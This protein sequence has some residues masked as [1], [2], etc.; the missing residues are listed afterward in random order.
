M[1]FETDFWDT[2]HYKNNE[3]TAKDVERAESQLNVKF[4]ELL[5]KLLKIQ[6]G[7]YLKGFVFPINFRTSW[8]DD[9]VP[10]DELFGINFDEIGTGESSLTSSNYLTEEWGLP[11]SQVVLTGDGHW[12]ITLDYR[13]N[14]QTP[15]ISWIDVEVIEDIK[16]ANTFDEFIDQLVSNDE[17]E[18]Q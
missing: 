8:S 2:E 7:G 9:H 16:L 3:L 1:N 6:N 18:F 17:F 13:T 14:K 4:P 5:V 15:T 11:E 12:W 10:F